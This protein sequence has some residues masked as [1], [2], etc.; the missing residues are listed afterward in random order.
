MV[1]MWRTG[2]AHYRQHCY[3]TLWRKCCAS[4]EAFAYRLLILHCGQQ[5]SQAKIKAMHRSTVVHNIQL[6]RLS[7]NI[8]WCKLLEKWN[9]VYNRYV[10]KTSSLSTVVWP[11]RTH[12]KQQ[13]HFLHPSST[14]HIVS[15]LIYAIRPWLYILFIY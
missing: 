5:C 1:I 13:T 9:C 7:F 12:I 14:E 4:L 10:W 6:I 8:S 2:N 15:L 3:N 11:T